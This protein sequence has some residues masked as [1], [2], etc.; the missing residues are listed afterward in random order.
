MEERTNNNACQSKDTACRITSYN[1]CYTKL[2]RIKQVIRPTDGHEIDIEEAV[3][4]E[5]GILVNSGEFD[6]LDY[7]AAFNA[8][9]D[10]FEETGRGGRTINYRLR[11]WA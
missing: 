2:L 7:E 3:F 8:I 6:G 1:V 10:H 5:K 9:A 4:L 11:D